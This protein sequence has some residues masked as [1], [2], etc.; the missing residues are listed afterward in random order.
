MSGIIDF[1][2]RPPLG[3]FLTT[4]MFREKE[5][6]IARTRQLSL[7]PAPSLLE[8]SVEKLLAEMDAAGVQT[9]VVTGRN[10]GTGFG[11][12]RNEDVV[13]IAAKYPGRFVACGAVNP[14]DLTAALCDVDRI[15]GE[16]RMPAVSMEPG[17]APQPMRANDRRLY[18]IYA[19]CA[20]RALPVILTLS[21]ITGPDVSYCL[22]VDVDQVAHDFPTLKLVIAHAC[23]PWVHP[24]L[25]VAFRRTNIYL[26]PDI[27][28]INVPGRDD[29]ALAARTYLQDRF[30]FASGYP[31][32]SVGGAVQAYHS[33]GFE[34]EVADKI[35][36]RNAAAL[37][38]LT[39]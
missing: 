8:L 17:F 20:E 1:R 21:A 4:I 12:V 16:W 39:A 15:A 28:A 32:A 36:R 9:G 31:F 10:T 5:R 3:G 23:W 33:L 34:G 7:E 35:F 14:M 18:P 30:L 11:T 24:M 38:R 19:R 13:A 2:L 29:F 6:T 37:L 25:G 26:S 22:P 27:Y